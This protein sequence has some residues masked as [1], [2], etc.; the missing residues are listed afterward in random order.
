VRLWSPDGRRA[1][2]R[3]GT[4]AHVNPRDAP[5][6]EQVL[7]PVRP[8]QTEPLE[9]AFARARPLVAATRGLGELTLRRCLERTDAYLLLTGWQTL[10]N[11]TE[12]FRASP[13]YQRWRPL[14]HGCYDPS[15]VVEHFVPVPRTGGVR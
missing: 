10:E 12:G 14:L 11:H 13:E 8:G 7:L 3:R 2:R 15:P 5:V 4:I 6:F 9:A 1:E